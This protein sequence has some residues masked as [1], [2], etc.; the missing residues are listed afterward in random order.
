MLPALFSSAYVFLE[1]GRKKTVVQFWLEKFG[2]P[3]PACLCVKLT[4]LTQKLLLP[5]LERKFLWNLLPVSPTLISLS[6]LALFA[7][8]VAVMSSPL[9]FPPLSQRRL[10]N[11]ILREVE[12]LSL[13]RKKRRNQYRRT[14]THIHYDH[15]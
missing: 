9:C 13:F 5:G 3:R 12:T 1:L 8:L 7:G 6:R 11:C 4:P 10:R 14:C 2:Y 15:Y